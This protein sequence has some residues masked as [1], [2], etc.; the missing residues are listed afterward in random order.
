MGIG[1]VTRKQ[2]NMKNYKRTKDYRSHAPQYKVPSNMEIVVRP[3]GG[4]FIRALY[5][6]KKGRVA[7]CTA[8]LPC[9]PQVID[10]LESAGE[11]RGLTPANSLSEWY[12]ECNGHQL[13]KLMLQ[14]GL[15]PDLD[16]EF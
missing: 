12:A 13:D 6:D 15:D 10:A 8:A 4:V 11:Q 16:D 3:D 14:N 1:A 9:I 7:W 2:K 5:M